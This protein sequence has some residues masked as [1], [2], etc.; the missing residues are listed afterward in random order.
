[1]GETRKPRILYAVKLPFY[2]AANILYLECG[3]RHI[4]S[5]FVIIHWSYVQNRVQV[6]EYE[7]YLKEADSTELDPVI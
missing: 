1:M 2:G 5:P 3:D 6:I 7:P 4:V